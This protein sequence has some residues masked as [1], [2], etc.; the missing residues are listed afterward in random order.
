MKQF[1]KT[2]FGKLHLEA[3][4]MRLILLHNSF[5]AHAQIAKNMTYLIHPNECFLIVISRISLPIKS[6]SQFGQIASKSREL[7]ERVKK[8]TISG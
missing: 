5:H 3:V 8:V 6:T 1:Y 2:A 4:Y 7:S